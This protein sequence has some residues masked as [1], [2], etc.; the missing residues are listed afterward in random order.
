M[1]SQYWGIERG[2]QPSSVTTGSSTTS[3]KIE[4][5][6]DLTSGATKKD[7]ILALEALRQA[8]LNDRTTPLAQ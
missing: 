3:K 6:V 7:V 2:A 5:V 1:A 4:L 8:V